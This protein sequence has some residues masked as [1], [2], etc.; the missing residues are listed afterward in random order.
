MLCILC[1]LSCVN[2]IATKCE[3]AENSNG[4]CPQGCVCFKVLRWCLAVAGL[5]L[6]KHPR[7]M[8]NSQPSFLRFLCIGL[9]DVH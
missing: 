3:E 9:R 6:P 4:L 7:L 5:E 1:K 2:H 8:T